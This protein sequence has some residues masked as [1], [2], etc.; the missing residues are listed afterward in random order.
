VQNCT[1]NESALIT[2]VVRLLSLISIWPRFDWRLYIIGQ[3]VVI[4]VLRFAVTVT[5]D[6]RFSHSHPAAEFLRRSPI[7]DAIVSNNFLV[8]RENLSMRYNSLMSTIVHK[9]PLPGLATETC[10]DFITGSNHQFHGVHSLRHPVIWRHVHSRR[11]IVLW[12][13]FFLGH[14]LIKLG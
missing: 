1:L 12:S 14:Q 2:I 5:K 7:R 6:L 8:G 11:W 13:L 3:V 4:A 10:G 9:W